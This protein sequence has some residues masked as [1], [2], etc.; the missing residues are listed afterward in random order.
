[1]HERLNAYKPAA[2]V[3]WHLFLAA[4]MWTAVGAL[5]SVFGTRWLYS[6]IPRR[7]AVW[8]A[9][10]VA[11][12]IVKAR[13]AL[14]RAARRIVER[15][16]VRGDGRCIGGFLSLPTWGFVA[17]MVVAGRLLRGGWL[18]RP[19]VGFIY[20]AVGVALL[21]A[22]RRAWEAWYCVRATPASSVTPK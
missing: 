16:R 5:L 3:R 21:V 1:M 6:G 15:I 20:V 7:P 19:V 22:S 12:G 4:L 10:A 13:F 8:V 18:P 11:L 17:L 2:S 9:A 14:D